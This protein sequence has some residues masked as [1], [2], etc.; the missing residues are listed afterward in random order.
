M[1][2]PSKL[3]LR[4]IDE[5]NATSGPLRYDPISKSIYDSLTNKEKGITRSIVIKKMDQ[6]SDERIPTF[7]RKI[8]PKVFED[9][10]KDYNIDNK[11]TS[12]KVSFLES[13]YI[14]SKDTSHLIEII[15]LL[16]NPSLPDGVKR[17]ICGKLIALE[18]NK[19]ILDAIIDYSEKN[20]YEPLLIRIKRH[21]EL[22]RQYQDSRPTKSP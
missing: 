7:L 13:Q 11:A 16:N 21:L 18:P 15:E 2:K 8:A 14:I 5:L 10:A 3:L 4:L 22:N 12:W 20:T 1:D 17:F 19:M 6:S 9:L